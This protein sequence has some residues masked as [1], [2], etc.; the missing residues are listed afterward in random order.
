MPAAPII[1]RGTNADSDE[2][3]R[4]RRLWVAEQNTYGLTIASATDGASLP[5][6]LFLVAESDASLIG[7]II[8]VLHEN[9]DDAVGRG[10]SY[11]EV[12][13]LYVAPDYRRSGVGGTLLDSLVKEVEAQGISEFRVFSAARDQHGI[14]RFYERHGFTPWGIQF[15]R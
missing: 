15:F 4:L 1:R 13:E 11:A 7:F 9:A 5:E 12:D 3:E 6:G 10:G 8:A 2:V 14:M